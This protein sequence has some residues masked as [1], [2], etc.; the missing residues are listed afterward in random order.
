M[1]LLPEN[2]PV[3]QKVEDAKVKI[4]IYGAPMVGKT[5]L[6]SKFPSPIMLNTDGNTKFIDTPRILISDEI[7]HKGRIKEEIKMWSKFKSVIEELSDPTTN[8]YETIVLDLVEDL[9]EG[10]RLYVYDKLKIEHESDNPFKAWDIVTNEYLNTM[11]ELLTLDYNMV[12]LSHEDTTR[13][14]TRP[15]GDN[16]TQIKPNLRDKVALKLVGYVDIV[17]RMTVQGREQ[18]RVLSFKQDSV[19]FGGGRL[20]IRNK[21]IEPTFEN[22]KNLYNENLGG[23]K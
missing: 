9:Y 13:D 5:V 8:T 4:W 1:G 7:K 6:A 12:I 14:I 23:I 18:K 11:R 19:T 17:G 15:N 3:K 2:K 21:D 20:N 10:C 22:I 16:I